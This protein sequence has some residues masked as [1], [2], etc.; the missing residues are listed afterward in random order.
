[1]NGRSSK[2]RRV[3]GAM[4]FVGLVMT[5]TYA[6]TASNTVAASKAG[7]GSGTVSGYAISGVHYNLNATNPSTIDSV[8]FNLD[9]TPVAGS[10][11]RAQLEPA[12]T[13]YSCTTS[14][15]A[16][17]CTTTGAA[18]APVTGLRVVIAD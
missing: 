13:W 17:T 15:T 4:V 10:T 1:M 3:V 11:V 8:Q 5:A 16:V 7:D 6:L 9:S 2:K 14:G 12:A 18:V